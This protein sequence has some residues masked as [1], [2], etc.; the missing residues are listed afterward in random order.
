[1]L[2]RG[3]HATSRVATCLRFPGKHPADIAEVCGSVFLLGRLEHRD[4]VP[5]VRHAQRYSI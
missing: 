2:Y 3:R 5:V 4:K 1:M